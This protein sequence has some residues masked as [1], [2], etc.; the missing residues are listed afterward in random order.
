MARSETKKNASKDAGQALSDFVCRESGACLATS[1]MWMFEVGLTFER[2][3]DGKT[4]ALPR[5]RCKLKEITRDASDTDPSGVPLLPSRE[6]T[7]CWRAFIKNAVALCAGPA[8]ELKFRS[9]EG[10]P[11]GHVCHS[12]ARPLT[13]ASFGPR[14]VGM[15]LRSSAWWREACRL[16]DHPPLIW[17]AIAAVEGELF[18]G[19]LRLEPADPRPGD[20][21]KFVVPGSRAE[22]LIAGAGIEL[23]HIFSPHQC[24]PEC[25][26][27]SR[28]TSRRWERYLAEWAN[29]EPADAASGCRF[30]AKH[31]RSC[32]QR[33]P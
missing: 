2:D 21:V 27:P 29:E 23:P 12:D 18:S 10:L 11:R 3:Y 33:R 14:P 15:G 26:R 8:G 22:A 25:I 6:P 20:S 19:L 32:S 17:K 24:G 4:L 9:Q 1:P 28:R 7:F 30:P 16:V 13:I 5:G 31:F